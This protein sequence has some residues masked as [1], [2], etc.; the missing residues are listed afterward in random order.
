VREKKKGTGLLPAGN[1]RFQF[2]QLRQGKKA[3]LR[4]WP[5]IIS[6]F[7]GWFQHWGSLSGVRGGEDLEKKKVDKPADRPSD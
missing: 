1:R 7:E 3:K 5:G 6:C 2:V 4:P